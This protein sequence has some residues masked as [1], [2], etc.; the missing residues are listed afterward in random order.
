[1]RPGGALLPND[2]IRYVQVSSWDSI[3]GPIVEMIWAVDVEA[4]VD[5]TL[6]RY[7]ARQTLDGEVYRVEAD[8][9]MEIKFH[10]VPT[11]DLVMTSIVFSARPRGDATKFSLAVLSLGAARPIALRYATV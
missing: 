6:A 9:D 10:V 7:V 2:F 8:A 4:E 1:M 3:F 5:A 11:F